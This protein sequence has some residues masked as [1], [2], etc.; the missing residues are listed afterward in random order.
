[1]FIPRKYNNYILNN[2]FCVAIENLYI[3]MIYI[4]EYVCGHLLI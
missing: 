2:T 3:Y 1:M 4:I